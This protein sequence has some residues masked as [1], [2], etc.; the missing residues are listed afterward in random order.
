MTVTG[1]EGMLSDVFRHISRSTKVQITLLSQPQHENL[2]LIHLT[3]GEEVSQDRIR[4]IEPE[5]RKSYGY[6]HGGK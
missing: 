1:L 5:I 4:F 2:R 3:K 6:N